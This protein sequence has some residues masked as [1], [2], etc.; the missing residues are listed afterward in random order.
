MICAECGASNKEG[1]RFCGQC[2]ATLAFG[3]PTCGAANDPGDLYCGECGGLLD[4]QSAPSA[5]ARS[6]PQPSLHERKLVS[7]MFCDLVGFT[8]LSESRDPEEVRD[9]LSRYF[10]DAREIVARFG[11][12]IE[13][14]IG[15]AVM[16][17]WGSPT[18]HEDDAERAVRACLELLGHVDALGR[19][20]G[21]PDLKLR[22]GVLTGEAAVDRGAT[23]Q[24]MV[25]GDM[26][27]TASRLQSAARPGTVLVGEATYLASNKAIAYES[28]GDVELKGKAERV[29]AWEAKRVV[30][31]TAGRNRS[32][33]L[34]PPFVGRERELKTIKDALRVVSSERKPQLVSVL[35]VAGVGKSRL[36]WEFFKYLD[37]IAE[38]YYWHIGRCPAYGDGITFWALAEMVRMRA[39]ISEQ[40]DDAVARAKLSTALDDLSFSEGERQSVETALVVLLGLHDADVSA[41]PETLFASWRVFI[42]RLSEQYPTIWVFED[43]QWADDGLIDFIEHLLEW[44]RATPI[45]M[46]TLARTELLEA[47]PNWG[48]GQRNFTSLTL[49][50]LTDDEVGRLLE[51]VIPDLPAEVRRSIVQRAEGIPLYAVETIRTLIDKGTIVRTED[52][53]RLEG[54]LV[55]LEVP[56]SLH[57]LI[58]AR[59]DSL[60][61]WDR[62]LLQKASVLGKTFMPESLGAIVGG[63]VGDL[64]DRLRLLVR[65]ELLVYDNDPRSPERGQYG[66]VQSLMR[67]VAYQ[68]LSRKDRLDLHVGAAAFYESTNE[69]DLA[70]VVAAHYHEAY[71]LATDEAQKSLLEEKARRT[72]REAAQRAASL[73]SHEQ[74]VT[75]L[76]R[77]IELSRDER[78]KAVLRYEACL[79]ARMAEKI[80]I[81][82]ASGRLALEYF[83]ETGDIP[84]T[85]RTAR[86]MGEA[87]WDAGRLKDAAELLRPRLTAESLEVPEAAP[88]AAFL[89]IFELW[90]DNYQES[91]RWCDS[92]LDL[93][94]RFGDDSS[95]V[96][97]LVT[98]GNLALQAGR[99]TETSVYLSGAASTAEEL[100]LP[101]EAARACINLS[102][103]L[104]D[105]N[106][107]AAFDTAL[108]GVPHARAIGHSSYEITLLGN[109]CDVA[110]GL[111][112]WD[113]IRATSTEILGEEPGRVQDR[114]QWAG[115]MFS[116]RAVVEAAAGDTRLLA[117]FNRAG[118]EMKS[119]DPQFVV[120]FAWTEG[121]GAL[122]AGDYKRASRLLQEVT[123]QPWGLGFDYLIVGLVAAALGG[124][125]DATRAFRARRKLTKVS[126]PVAACVD[127]LGAAIEATLTGELEEAAGLFDDLASRHRSIGSR[128]Y[129]GLEQMTC[130]AL[131][132]NTE[133]GA[134][135][136]HEARSVFE[137]IG[138]P[139]LVQRLEELTQPQV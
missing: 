119:E 76:G 126:S 44:A 13:K 137:E 138:A 29:P 129:L 60:D 15:D 25:V 14:F 132:P 112:R 89:G 113:W 39:R 66:F 31:G 46:V 52:G 49:D 117:E 98:K 43:L 54:P 121:K 34:E 6:Q 91:L 73:G 1:R 27:N 90:L 82:E 100:G 133:A 123:E 105:Y 70:S 28:F 63:E 41:R 120:E 17:V 64:T 20:V 75:Y 104:L 111:G 40:D 80:D 47:R 88:A 59:L 109:A 81:A 12:V 125:L 26:V 124:D 79:S 131:L 67:E 35:G 61:E 9:L 103:H 87:F 16:A 114:S 30:A 92:A 139:V 50:P 3:C 72:L 57:A 83:E 11:G 21:V 122:F 97:A 71:R 68:T 110:F 58:A 118:E 95:V 55:D 128:F 136:A 33:L 127:V 23:N 38:I 10:G 107:T 102:Y 32:D 99:R 115:P 36:G 53:Y 18:A 4:T 5:V 37:G 85:L 65:K 106:P 135:A 74:A 7:V 93:G 56:D 116:N 51:G 24:G 78:E 130:A 69:Y 22:G 45:L 2:G 8:P 42:E 77:A 19:E 84:A 101:R 96:N 86:A 94:H 108:R 134:K 62:S 48:A